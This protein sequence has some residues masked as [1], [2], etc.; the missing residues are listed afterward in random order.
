MGGAGGGEQV[1]KNYE[2]ALHVDG[3]NMGPSYIVGLGDYD[4]GQVR[5]RLRLWPLAA[6]RAALRC[7]LDPAGSGM[8]PSGLQHAT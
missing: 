2:T 5:V 8:W 6:G 1:N 7:A 4:G 3:N